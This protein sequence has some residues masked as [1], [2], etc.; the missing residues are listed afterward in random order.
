MK[1]L[2]ERLPLLS[3]RQL[4]TIIIFLLGFMNGLRPLADYDG[5]WHLAGGRAIMEQGHILHTD[6]FSYTMPGREWIMHEWGWEVVLFNVYALL[7]PTGVIILKALIAGLISA[8]ILSLAIRRGANTLVALLVTALAVNAMCLWFNERPQIMQPVFVL[9]ALHL[10]HSYRRGRRRAMLWYPL[11]MVVWVNVHGSFP[12]GIVLLI[13][14]G[15]TQLLQSPGHG[16]RRSLP[17]L[18]RRPSLLIILVIVLS[19]TA[20]FLGPNG[21]R[22]AMYP[23][24]YVGGKL[25]W[26]IENVAE[27]KAPD[28]HETYLRPMEIM[29]LIT[30]VALA[31]SPLSP[32]P[33]DLLLLLM[34]VHMLLQW[35]R[36]GPLF[37]TLAA[38]IAAVHLSAWVD[39]L[40]GQTVRLERQV[41][42]SLR[43]ARA[44]AAPVTWAIVVAVLVAALWQVPWRAPLDKTFVL[45]R[46]PV[47]A[48]EVV[49]LNDLKGRMYNVYHWGG[50]L[51]WR[52][53]RERPVMIDGRA[54]V[55][56]EAIWNDYKKLSH[57]EADWRK[58]L[59]KYKIQYMLIE[60]GWA[61]ARVL[62]ASPDFTCIYQDTVA[63]LYVRNRGPNADVVARYRKG[64]LI[65]PTD[66][67]PN[68]EAIL[69]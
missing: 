65:L 24:D 7:G 39:A 27:W 11:L 50:Y 37:A 66:D 49:A 56:G 69:W 15:L 6:P 16:I 63:R 44:F 64:K 53:Y 18:V 47:R 12:L 25:A 10:M 19:A 33:F 36:N 17:E 42:E 20:C 35:G 61:V 48:A 43:E 5:W 28:W 31:I 59:D 4:A 3:I 60:S 67:L 22:G 51:L 62:D 57:A 13:L 34:A 38:P 32:A 55:Y 30:I 45:S 41:S 46:F 8:G 54:D 68:A 14:F 58:M 52:F 21:A 40:A 29:L 23:L 26:A 2:C 1:R 9:A